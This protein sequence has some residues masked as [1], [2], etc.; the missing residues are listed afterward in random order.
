[1]CQSEKEVA[2][3]LSEIMVKT[4]TKWLRNYL[5]CLLLMISVTGSVIRHSNQSR[6]QRLVT[7]KFSVLIMPRANY[8]GMENLHYLLTSMSML[9]DINFTS[10]CRVGLFFLLFNL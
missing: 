9:Q 1:M 4:I 7:V 3:E 2:S 8:E 6:M 5:A 10:K